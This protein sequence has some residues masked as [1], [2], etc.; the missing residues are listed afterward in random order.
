MVWQQPCKEAAPLVG[1]SSGLIRYGICD[2]HC[3]WASADESTQGTPLV[4]TPLRKVLQSNALT[5]G[6][7]SFLG[8]QDLHIPLCSNERCSR[9]H[10]TETRSEWDLAVRQRCSKVMQA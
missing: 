3:L 10:E 2:Q 7:D 5:R 9:Q 6:S 8:Q 4:R 1:A